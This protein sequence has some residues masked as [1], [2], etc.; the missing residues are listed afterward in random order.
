MKS[1]LV[2]YSSS[3]IKEISESMNKLFY[4]LKVNSGIPSDKNSDNII[5]YRIKNSTVLITNDYIHPCC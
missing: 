5:M 3:K 1:I 2:Y 4:M